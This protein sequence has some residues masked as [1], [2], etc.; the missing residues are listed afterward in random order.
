MAEQPNKRVNRLKIGDEYL[1]IEPANGTVTTEKFSDAIKDSIHSHNNMAALNSITSTQLEGLHT[2]DNKDILDN[3]EVALTNELKTIYDNKVDSVESKTLTTNDLTN[4]LKEHYD[5][6]YN[7]RHTHTNKDILDSTTASYTTELDNKLNGIEEGAEVNPTKVSA[8]E[9]DVPYLV[10]DDISGKANIEDVYTKG[11]TDSLIV[12]KIA[13]IIANAP[14][15]FDTL[16]EIS[17]WISSHSNDVTEMNSRIN[18]KQEKLTERQ[19]NAVNSGITNEKVTKYDNYESTINGK[20]EKATTIEGY[21]IT[22]SVITKTIEDE[23]ELDLISGIYLC[24]NVTYI[25]TNNCQL[26]F[27]STTNKSYRKFTDN[28]EWIEDKLT[29]TTYDVVTNSNDGL[30]SSLD[31]TKL[32]TIENGATRV[33]EKTVQDWGFSKTIGTYVY[34][35]NGIP[36]NDL[37]QDV[38]DSLINADTAY[39][40]PEN[41][42]TKNDLDQNVQNSLNLADSALQNVPQSSI[43]TLGLVKSSTTGTTEG[44]DYNVEVIEDGTMKVN[45]PWIEYNTFTGNNGELIPKTKNGDNVKYLKGDG[46][47]DIP[48]DVEVTGDGVALTDISSENGHI[49]VKKDLTWDNFK[50]TDGISKEDL[51]NTVKESLG[52][53]DTAYQL[54]INGMPE[55]DLSQ[56]I[57]ENLTRASQC[58]R[59]DT[60][61]NGIGLIDNEDNCIDRLI[62]TLIDINNIECNLVE[63]NLIVS[64]NEGNEYE[65]FAFNLNIAITVFDESQNII[66]K[67]SAFN[68]Q[69]IESLKNLGI[70]YNDSTIPNELSITICGTILRHNYDRELRYQ[71]SGYARYDNML[72]ITKN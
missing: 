14:E 34:P 48:T 31:K 9:N 62:D 37:S 13:E 56:D 72:S 8:F 46:T 42:I 59:Q 57:Q 3:I 41:G 53:A 6:S 54:P 67:Y 63:N 55:N 38:Q 47:W 30:M 29:D 40:K 1:D 19:L 44:R 61:I 15:D 21:G 39:Q 71:Q 20:A 27:D 51:H 4:E 60:K 7:K 12:E 2:H 58:L 64:I 17:D 16:R 45:V 69:S 5:E 32:D 24:N 25:V 18:S 23:S 65:D 52:K 49:T 10:G 36:K 68:I 28:N 43:N 11:E 22:N 35:D 26:K 70:Q 66:G 33:L 50:P